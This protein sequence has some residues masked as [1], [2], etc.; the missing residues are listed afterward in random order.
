MKIYLAFAAIGLLVPF[1]YLIG[2]AAD[3]L[4]K[5]AWSWAIK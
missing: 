4:I 1:F 2:M 3:A 5:R